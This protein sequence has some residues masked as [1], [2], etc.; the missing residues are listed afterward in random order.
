[1]KKNVPMFGEN[2]S[3]Q[4]TC[5]CRNGTALVLLFVPLFLRSQIPEIEKYKQDE[6]AKNEAIVGLLKEKNNLLYLNLLPSVSYKHDPVSGIGFLSV[7]V[8]FGSLFT[9]FQRKNRNDILKF[10]KYLRA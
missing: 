10:P 6:R 1:M 3:Y 2:S 9:Y 4:M 7:G 5:L 8:D